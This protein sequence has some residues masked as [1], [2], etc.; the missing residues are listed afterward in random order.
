MEN[1]AKIRRALPGGKG[2]ARGLSGHQPPNFT[3]AM[4]AFIVAPFSRRFLANSD[5]IHQGP[6]T[7][8]HRSDCVN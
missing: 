7:R 6:N 8:K 1:T 2:G 4:T 5:R 3:I